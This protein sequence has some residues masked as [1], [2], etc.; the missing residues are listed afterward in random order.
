MDIRT[1]EAAG[2]L[3]AA[4][5]AEAGWKVA[6]IVVEDPAEGDSPVCDDLTKCSLAERI[7]E[8][9]LIVPAGSG[10][11]SDLG[12]WLAFE[13]DAPAVTFATAASMNGYASA[14]IAPTI[15][16]LKSL[17]HARPPLAVLS[18]PSVLR[19]APYE[20]TTAGLGD[21]LAKSVSSADWYLNHLLFGDYYCPKSVELTSRIDPLYSGHAA[22]L[23]DHRDDAMAAL[24][25]AVLLTG[26]ATALAETSCPISGAEHLVSHSL[27]A[28][29][30]R[31]GHAHDLHGRQVGV[32]T[33]LAAELYRRVLEVESPQLVDP[34][35]GIDRRFWGALADGLAERFAA[36]APRLEAL[37][38]KLSRG[39]SW[40]RLRESLQ[41]LLRPPE[42]IHGCLAAAGAACRADHI[43]CDRDRLRSAF[44]HAHEIRSRLTVLDLARVL[45]V[46]PQAA[47]E[48]L[49]V[50]A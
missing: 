3:A 32:G 24:F 38:Q 4:A 15:K 27:D 8:V 13:A 36:K 6:E 45:G 40:D 20:L 22:G 12:K 28:M 37:A 42:Q 47:E 33:V 5:L 18:S 26:A 7:G 11:I 9:D 35:R 30:S 25:D 10:V 16:G 50:W 2:R 44:V 17:L 48:I 39:Q 21:V 43:G 1:R 46:M 31:D 34:P 19:D 23:A 49:D 14:N 29:S 41:P